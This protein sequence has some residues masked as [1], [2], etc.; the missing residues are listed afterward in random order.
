M[1]ELDRRLGRRAEVQQVVAD[2]QP[3]PR[4][5]GPV[6][7]RLSVL[8]RLAR[9]LD[10]ARRILV[11][12]LPR[13]AGQTQPLRRSR[14]CPQARHPRIIEFARHARQEDVRCVARG[15]TRQRDFFFEGAGYML[16]RYCP[17]TSNNADVIWPSEQ[18]RT[19]AISTAN[20]L[21]S[22]I[23]ACC[24]RLSIAGASSA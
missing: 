22:S 6:V 12:Q 1:V 14:R 11:L 3:R 5:A 16:R 13:L 18:Q 8:Q 19:A 24:K 15:L 4:L 9:Q 23:T 21:R 20:T 2:G 10:R 7:I 17:P